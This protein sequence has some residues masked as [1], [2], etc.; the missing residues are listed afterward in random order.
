MSGTW[1]DI[2]KRM[3]LWPKVCA[4]DAKPAIQ[5][6]AFY[7]AQCNRGCL[8]PLAVADRYSLALVNYNAG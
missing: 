1:A 7:M 4:F 3:R 6:A 5:A 8:S 2:L